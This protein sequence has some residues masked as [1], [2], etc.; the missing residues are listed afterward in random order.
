MEMNPI[1]SKLHVNLMVALEE[2][3]GDHQNDHIN[4][5]NVIHHIGNTDGF[6]GDVLC[7]GIYLMLR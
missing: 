7:R 3:S 6:H 4:H 2:K 1:F 5:T